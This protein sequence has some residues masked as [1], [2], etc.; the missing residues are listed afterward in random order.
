MESNYL[1]DKTGRDIE[2]ER[3][4]GLLS[5]FRY[6][7]T[8]APDLPAS[9]VIE[10][11]KQ[12]RRRAWTIFAASAGFACVLIGVFWFMAGTERPSSTDLASNI[13]SGQNETTAAAVPAA[14]L[15]APDAGPQAE[16]EISPA[17]ASPVEVKRQPRARYAVHR[18]AKRA[19]EAVELTAEEKYAYDQLMLA[20]SITS[21]KLKMVRDKVD[22]R[23]IV[24]RRAVDK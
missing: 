16:N 17:A 10:F 3:L 20:L 23:E 6:V 24:P 11:A 7:E 21:S 1:T 13:G 12:P 5:E 19:A 4:E 18:P 14:D 2:V 22:G 9:N 15:P 8:A